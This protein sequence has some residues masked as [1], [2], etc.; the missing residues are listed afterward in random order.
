MVQN[1][2]TTPRCMNIVIVQRHAKRTTPNRKRFQG[3]HSPRPLLLPRRLIT[4]LALDIF[5]PCPFLVSLA[6]FPRRCHHPPHT[7]GRLRHDVCQTTSMHRIDLLLRR[8][9]QIRVNRKDG[10]ESVDGND[11]TKGVLNVITVCGDGA[12]DGGDDCTP[13]GRGR[14]KDGGDLG[15]GT[16]TANRHGKDEGED[17]GLRGVVSLM[18][19]MLILEGSTSKNKIRTTTATPA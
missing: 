19:Y 12:H 3:L 16:E 5:R 15:L 4:P 18:M 2:R 7:S 11:N 9:N 17:T 14:E 8:R 6:P 10:T 13:R 1:E